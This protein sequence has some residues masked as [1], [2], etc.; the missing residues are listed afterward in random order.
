MYKT[1]IL[2]SS[3]THVLEIKDLLRPT[4]YIIYRDACTS[5]LSDTNG[6]IYLLLLFRTASSGSGR[7]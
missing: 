4:I 1:F 6:F 5:F 3:S 2:Y 7:A